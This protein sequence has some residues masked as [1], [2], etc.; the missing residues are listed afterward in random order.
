MSEQDLSVDEIITRF[1]IALDAAFERAGQSVTVSEQH[2]ARDAI[3][4]K[5]VDALANGIPH[6]RLSGWTRH[7]EGSGEYSHASNDKI[8]V[9]RFGKGG[10]NPKW[11]WRLVGEEDW[12]GPFATRV[13][14]FSAGLME[15]TDRS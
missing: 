8:R 1:C 13:E 7:G 12:R 9:K 15:I 5:R 2:P 3:Q 10:A 11:I 6:F 14:A 4:Q